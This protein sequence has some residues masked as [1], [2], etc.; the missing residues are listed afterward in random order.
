MILGFN[1]SPGAYIDSQ[2][3]HDISE[4]LNVKT[5]DLMNIYALHRMRRM[6]PNYLQMKIK[7]V[8]V[9]SFYTG[10]SFKHYVGRPDYAITIFLS[11]NDVLP[12][13]FEGMIR[14]IAYELLPD[15]DSLT[16]E[17]QFIEYFNLLKE[18]DLEPYWEEY[19]E[20]EGSKIATIQSNKADEEKEG[21]SG[22]TIGVAAPIED[23]SFDDQFDQ[24][25]KEELKEEI[26]EL[27]QIINEKNEKIRELT[28]KLTE[29]LE[30][31]SMHTEQIQ[32][33]QAQ[34]NDA[35][36][37]VDDW[38]MK[39]A[40]LA[41][42]NA[43]LMETVRKLTEMSMQQT[44]EMERQG[45]KI[46]DLKKEIEDKVNQIENLKTK[47]E[48]SEAK[49]TQSTIS[50]EEIEKKNEKIEKL[51]KEKKDL[52]SKIADLEKELKQIKDQCNDHLETIVNLKK[53]IKEVKESKASQTADEQED[54][55]EKIIDLKKDLKIIRRERDHYKKIVQDNNLL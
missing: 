52:N 15:R 48:N 4:K 20:G 33:L 43:I 1:K 46:L 19:I 38:S 17:E 16:F 53:E 29:G 22:E 31:D 37:K 23:L 35:N 6:E 26:K 40:D 10:F 8:S 45:R 44:E 54:L 55:Y 41:E 42:K 21:E 7:S 2:Y 25:E 47:L 50:E 12:N 32:I 36:A 14:R 28:K 51:T 11:E 27:Q 39:L 30:E 13:N 49:A 9:A 18:G 5:S 34:L 3:P 24:L